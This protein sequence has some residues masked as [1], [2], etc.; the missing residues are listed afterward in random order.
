[1]KPIYKPPLQIANPAW[2]PDG[3]KIAFIAGLM[4]DEPSVG[5]DIYTIAAAGGEAANVTPEMKATANW[6]AWTPEG[7]IVVWGNVEGD[8]G[9][10]MGDPARRRIDSLWRG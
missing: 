7:K 5:G 4:S 9:A 3:K 6:L 8:S 2:S 10:A 1:M